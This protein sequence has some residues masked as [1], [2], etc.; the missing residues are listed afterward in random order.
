MKALLKSFIVPVLFSGAWGVMT[1]LLGYI[2]LSRVPIGYMFFY[3]I[4]MTGVVVAVAISGGSSVPYARAAL[5]GFITGFI[6]LLVSPMFPTLAAVLAG[7]SLGGGLSEGKGRFGGLLDCAVSTLKGMIVFPIV[8]Y[9]GE[10]LGAC[11]YIFLDSI[12]LG[13]V[14]WAA[15]LGLGVCII[16]F[17]AFRSSGISGNQRSVRGLDE[18]RDETSEIKRDLGE[19]G[20]GIDST[21]SEG[22]HT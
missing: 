8:I 20:S 12:F 18:F 11:V 13:M 16:R 22:A 3:P 10:I 14:F 7:A 9:T 21:L 6:Y 15:W 2:F 4:I 5:T 17:P 1:Y 19:L